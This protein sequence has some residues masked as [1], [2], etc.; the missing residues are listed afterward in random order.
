MSAK[1]KATTSDK[2]TVQAAHRYRLAQ[3]ACLIR[4]FREQGNALKIPRPLRPTAAD[5]REAE[6]AE[7]R[8]GGR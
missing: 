4:L 3:A 8:A 1:R 7:R 2:L 5:F 6:A